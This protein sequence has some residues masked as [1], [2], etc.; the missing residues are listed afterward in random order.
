MLLSLGAAL[1]HRRNLWHDEDGAA[2]AIRTAQ[3]QQVHPNAAGLATARRRLSVQ[4]VHADL[5]GLADWRIACGVDTVAMEST[6]VLDSP[7][8]SWKHA[9]WRWCWSTPVHVRS[10]RPQDRRERLRVA[11]LCTRSCHRL[12]RSVRCEALL[13]HRDS[14]RTACSVH[15]MQGIRPDERPSAPR[16]QRPER[17]QGLAITDAILAG[18]RDPA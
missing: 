17:A 11:A 10:P 6:G 7:V 8:R 13:L 15:H 3:P 2:K 9:A 14:L 16:H 5:H 12:T 1:I 4:S 18:E